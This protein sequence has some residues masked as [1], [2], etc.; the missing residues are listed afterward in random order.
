MTQPTQSDE[1]SRNRQSPCRC[2][3]IVPLKGPSAPP[4]I[5]AIPEANSDDELSVLPV[6]AANT[7]SGL[8]FGGFQEMIRVSEKP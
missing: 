4:G 7:E 2:G 3:R 1:E 8:L 6:Y 5:A